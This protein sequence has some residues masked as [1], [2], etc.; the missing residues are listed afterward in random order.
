MNAVL[1][2]VTKSRSL[3]LC[4]TRDANHPH[5]QHIH[6]GMRSHLAAPE[7]HLHYWRGCVGVARCLCLATVSSLNSSPKA[8]HIALITVS[9][10]NSSTL[11]CYCCSSLPVPS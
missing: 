8:T 3:V 2:S 10:Y 9:C 11:L 4:P 5:V 7:Q 1:S 6:G